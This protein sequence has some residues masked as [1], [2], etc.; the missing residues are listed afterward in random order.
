MFVNAWLVQQS[1]KR[2][3]DY[4]SGGPQAHMLDVWRAGAPDIDLYCPDIYRPVFSELCSL[5]TRNNNPLFIPEARAGEQGAGQ[6]FY[7]T[8]RHNSIGYSPFGFER[9]TPDV[10][11]D[12]MTRAYRVASGMSDLI[13][14]AQRNGTINSVLLS[15]EL[16]PSEEIALGDYKF[17]FEIYRGRQSDT[18]PRD[19]YGMIISTAPDEFLIYGNNIQVSFSPA[20][21]GPLIAG[22]A[23]VDEG[24][25]KNGEWIPG[26]RLNGDDIMLDYDLSKK[27]LENKTG[28]GLKFEN[29]NENIQ[30]VKLYRYE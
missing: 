5:Y 20:T 11:N 30:Q 7:A 19:S 24:R 6:F 1:D 13:L 23:R 27:A 12:P 16:N 14:E 9:R 15:P 17:L 18:L 22:I 8:G 28:T 25:F 26:R 29:G 4:P 3:G 21:A 2:P 10:E